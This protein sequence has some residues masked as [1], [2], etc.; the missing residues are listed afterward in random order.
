M[1]QNGPVTRQTKMWSMTCSIKRKRLPKNGLNGRSKS[2]NL[3]EANLRAINQYSEHRN[4][5]HNLD[6]FL[7]QID[8]AVAM[9]DN[10]DFDGA[11]AIYTKLLE[12][13]P[14]SLIYFE[15]GTN[16]VDRGDLDRGDFD[17]AI[18]DLTKAIELDEIDADA[19][20]NRGNAYYEKGQYEAAI[21]DCTTRSGGG[22]H[23]GHVEGTRP[24]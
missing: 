10:G 12:E 22:E 15:R 23:I 9:H 18:L 24:K 16:Y 17:N 20:V 19:Y 11:I 13:R 6:P 21:A 14:I 7:A 4:M 3:T 5:A 2:D 1:P 8:R